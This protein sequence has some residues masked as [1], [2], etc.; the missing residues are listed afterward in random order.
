MS[1]A[2]PDEGRKLT[3]VGGGGSGGLVATDRFRKKQKTK[4]KSRHVAAKF[5]VWGL[6]QRVVITILKNLLYLK[7]L[8][9]VSEQQV[10]SAMSVV[11]VNKYTN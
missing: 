9:S 7:S 10:P 1:L 11:N 3:T 2:D 8:Q 5:T 4:K 6:K